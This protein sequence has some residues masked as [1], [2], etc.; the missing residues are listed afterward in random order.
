M[1]SWAAPGCR[2]VSG[3]KLRAALAP[4]SSHDGAACSCP[5]PKTETMRAAA[6]PV[7]RLERALAHAK[8]PQ[9]AGNGLGWRLQESAL[10]AGASDLLTVRG[11]AKPVKPD[12]HPMD[13]KFLLFVQPTRRGLVKKPWHPLHCRRDIA[14]VTGRRLL[15]MQ[16]DTEFPWF[17]AQCRGPGFG[18]STAHPHTV[19]NCVERSQRERP[20]GR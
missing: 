20:S 12:G 15:L 2:L 10:D 6:T 18:V 16:A 13:Q 11:P 14:S 8:L 17:L 19:D 3:G 4:A 7:A 5:H 1:R 9:L